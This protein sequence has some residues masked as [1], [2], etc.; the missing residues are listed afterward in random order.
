MLHAFK[1]AYFLLQNTDDDVTNHVIPVKSQY[2]KPGS[3]SFLGEHS[4]FT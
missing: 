1:S 3:N 4:C 2:Q